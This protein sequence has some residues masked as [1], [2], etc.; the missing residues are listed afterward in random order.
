MNERLPGINYPSLRDEAVAEAAIALI[1]DF[2]FDEAQ[3]LLKARLR[4]IRGDQRSWI[5]ERF[6][7]WYA[8]GQAGRAASPFWEWLHGQEP[9]PP[10]G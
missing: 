8:L 2:R 6:D 1:R 9:R 3:K 4:Q 7:E 10:L 5:E